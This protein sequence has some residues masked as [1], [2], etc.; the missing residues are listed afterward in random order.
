METPQDITR[1]AISER[2]RE[3]RLVSTLDLLDFVALA[4]TDLTGN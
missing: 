2:E 1:T 3:K 4:L